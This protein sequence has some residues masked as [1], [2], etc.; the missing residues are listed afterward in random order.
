MEKFE[1]GKT[2]RG[3]SGVGYIDLTII[4]RTA[5]S[6][7]V[8]TSFGE[9]RC[10]I[11]QKGKEDEAINFKSWYSRATDIYSKEQQEEDSYYQA[12]YS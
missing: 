4:K 12:Y 6:V 7:V 2:Y 3:T 11:K 10:M 9:N 1:V 8:K 5:K